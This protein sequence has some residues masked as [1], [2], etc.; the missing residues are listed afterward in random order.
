M[1][2]YFT[3]PLVKM[4]PSKGL[5][6]DLMLKFHDFIYSMVLWNY[7]ERIYSFYSWLTTKKFKPSSI[8]FVSCCS[9]ARNGRRIGEGESYSYSNA[10]KYHLLF[11]HVIL[12]KSYPKILKIRVDRYL[13][14]NKIPH[15]DK[16]SS[17]RM[18]KIR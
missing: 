3:L 14:I 4:R 5:N 6:L 12:R 8:F 9:V 15:S 16:N 13:R 11:V 2:I 7:L 17:R 10:L 18:L 1:W